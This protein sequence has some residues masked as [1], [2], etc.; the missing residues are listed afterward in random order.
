M[1]KYILKSIH[2]FATTFIYFIILLF[3][4][5]CSTNTNYIDYKNGNYPKYYKQV[6]SESSL[7]VSARIYCMD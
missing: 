5:S 3:L 4:N 7:N 2:I 1:E 6:N